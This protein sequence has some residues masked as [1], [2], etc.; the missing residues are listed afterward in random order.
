MPKFDAPSANTIASVT[1]AVAGVVIAIL[2]ALGKLTPE[3]AV[4]LVPDCPPPVTC[5]EPAPCPAETAPAA[6]EPVP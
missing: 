2:L 1:A 4:A 5:P 6:L 3:Q